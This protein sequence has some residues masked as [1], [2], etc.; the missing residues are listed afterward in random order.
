LPQ[1]NVRNRRQNDSF[2]LNLS[3]DI[4]IEDINGIQDPAKITDLRLA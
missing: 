1:L 3:A 2:D 4:G